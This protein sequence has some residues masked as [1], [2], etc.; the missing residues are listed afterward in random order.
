MSKIRTYIQ[1]KHCSYDIAIPTIKKLMIDEDFLILF[2]NTSNDIIYEN[3]NSVDI[4]KETNGVKLD[5][6][7][8]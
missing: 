8:I 5:V 4:N 2:C 6:T 3:N 7:A 1:Y